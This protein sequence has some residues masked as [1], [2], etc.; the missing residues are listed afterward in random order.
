VPIM[1]ETMPISSDPSFSGSGLI[2]G[3]GL[4]LMSWWKPILLLIPFVPWAILISK[5]FDKHAA[6]FFLPRENWNVVHL[7]VGLVAFFVAILMPMRTELAFWMGMLAVV[8]L[9][10]ID[11][12]VF[13]HMANKDE[14]VPEEFH[15]KLDF[16]SFTEAKAKR[17]AEKKQGKVELVM[18]ASDK[19]VLAPPNMDQPEFATRVAA[20]TM[21]LKG[22]DARAS[23]MDIAPTGKDNAYQVSYIVDGVRQPGDILAGP[24]AL[25]VIDIW[26]TAAK[27]DLQE[28]RRKLET[29]LTVER[30]ESRK[31]VRVT[32]SGTQTGLRMTLLVDPEGQVRRKEADLGLLEPQ[33]AEIKALV[34][35]GRGIVLISAPPDAGR[36]TTLYAITKMHDAYT[37]NVQTV[38]LDIQDSMEGVRQNKFDPQSEG[39]EF[40]TLVRSILRRDPDVVSI[41]ELPD[42]STA[43]EI[44][45]ADYERMR[46]YVSL[47]TENSMK[48]LAAWL[49]AVGENDV[50][51]KNLKGVISQRLVRKLCT[52]CRLAY[53]P[54]AD[55]LKK[56]GLPADKVKQLYKKGGQ[57]LIKNKPEVCPLCAGVGYSGQEGVF[58]VFAFQPAEL[59]AIG[60]GDIATL[61]T[62]LRKRG[63]PTI[64]QAAIKKALDGVTSVEEVAR[65]TAEAAPAAPASAP[66][67]APAAPGVPAP[68]AKP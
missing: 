16:S 5:V 32:T 8:F 57:V 10:A 46:V 65:I 4:M 50:A 13:M 29:A 14:R 47:P 58:E 54:S 15:L 42:A 23:Q 68:A 40:S 19:S 49:K 55:T 43:K 3:S 20:E 12:F 44:A 37:K 30:G 59:A 66:R 6:R 35:D 63:Q 56:L 28:R 11:V 2:L 45:K 18:R 33:M 9:L 27:L 7:A 53:Q 21:F 39:P 67:A 51:V 41:A 1:P 60:T 25:K 26:K 52:N 17:V 22:L 31:K 61:R 64:Q 38:E 36:T 62:E 24:D 48:A 34:A